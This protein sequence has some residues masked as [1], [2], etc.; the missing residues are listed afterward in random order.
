MSEQ[1]LFIS[2]VYKGD[3]SD[4]Y[5]ILRRTSIEPFS[6]KDVKG[7]T[8]LHIG[9]LN[10]NLGLVEFLIDYIR[11]TYRE[12]QLKILTQWSNIPTEEGFI[13]LHLASFKG[14]HKICEKLVEIGSDIHKVNNQGLGMIHVAAQGDQPL[15]LAYFKERGLD[16]EKRDEKGGTALHWSSYMGCE[17]ASGVLL[18]WNAK[19]N[20]QDEDGNTPLHLA[21]IA[22][23]SR[24]VRNLLLK[25]AKR[26]IKDGKGRL[27]I[28]VAIENHHESL[29]AM[30]KEPNWLS[31][32]GMKPPLRP[33]QTSY[34]SLISFI[35]FFGGGTYTTIL[36]TSQYIPDIPRIIYATLVIITFAVFV[37]VCSRDPGYLKPEPGMTMLKLYETY[38]P[39]LVCSDCMI[40]RPAR[41]RHCQVCYKCVSKFDHHCP[42]INNCVGARNLGWFFVFIN[43][44]W[45]T[46]ASTVVIN[47]VALASQEIDL[48]LVDIPYLFFKILAGLLCVFGF[49]C[50]LPVSFLVTV[51]YQNFCKNMTTNERFSKSKVSEDDDIKQLAASFVN[52]NQSKLKNFADMCCNS[53]LPRR[54][55]GERRK[56]EISEVS[57]VEIVK[58]YNDQYGDS[59][60][61]PLIE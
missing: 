32:C 60:K 19:N 59:S 50:I 26:N 29:M 44:I 4:V 23:N 46:L 5:R 38:E 41:S 56:K 18:A 3:V 37:I 49:V 31:E 25:G 20:I 39:H 35:L 14:H 11:Q 1:Q 15:I 45:L 52:P 9:S 53:S 24:I 40:Y 54:T 8:A 13:A 47:I 28:D 33:P 6:C 27:A 55:S 16:I 34:V 48:E 7:Y 42:W 22:G 30:L 21:T 57:F 36:F 51:H 61:V 10:G 58:G 12:N 43:L 2:A 17:M